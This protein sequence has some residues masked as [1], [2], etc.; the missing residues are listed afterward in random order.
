MPP[1]KATMKINDSLPGLIEYQLMMS[2]QIVLLARLTGPSRRAAIKVIANGQLVSDSK[3][4]PQNHAL[5]VGVAKQPPFNEACAVCFNPACDAPSQ[6]CNFDFLIP[7]LKKGPEGRGSV[8]CAIPFGE[9]SG[10]M[11]RLMQMSKEA[12][13]LKCRVPD[14]TGPGKFDMTFKGKFTNPASSNF[15]LFHESKPMN[16][17]CTCGLNTDGTYSLTTSYP[18]SPF[19]GFIAGICSTLSVD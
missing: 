11:A 6:P 17:I 19:Q 4:T 13:R 18:M 7:A 1:I 16:D 12:I 8:S 15:I 5:F 10:L 3:F 9:S 2:G 14:S